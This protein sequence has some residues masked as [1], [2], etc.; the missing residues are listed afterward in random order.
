MKTIAERYNSLAGAYIKLSDEFHQLDVAH[1]NLKQKL[2]PAIKAIKT[3]QSL[4]HQLQQDNAHLEQTIQA[5]TDQQQR[6]KEEQRTLEAKEVEQSIT[7]NT[8]TEEKTNLQAT[9]EAFQTKYKALANFEVLLQ[10]EPQAVLAEAEQQMAL[11]E[12]TL[13]EIALNSDPDL[14][15]DEQQLIEAYQ[16][17]DESLFIAMEISKDSNS[18]KVP[19]ILPFV[20]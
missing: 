6:L 15:E 12:E 11:V 4:T 20:A 16:D 1:M 18:L 5:L 8:L 9:L 10:S 13:Q 3:Y 14:S 2:L 19:N 17:E 7:I